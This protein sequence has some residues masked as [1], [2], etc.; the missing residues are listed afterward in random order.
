MGEGDEAMQTRGSLPIGRRGY[1]SLFGIG[2]MGM[3][4]SRAQA[5]EAK[6]RSP[7]TTSSDDEEI[8]RVRISNLILRER[9]ARDA[10]RWDE[11]RASYHPDST[12]DI[13]WFKGK[14]P[15]FVDATAELFTKRLRSFHQLEPPVV[16]INNDRALVDVGAAVHLPGFVGDVAV[17]VISHTRALYRVERSA[18]RWSISHLTSIYVRDSMHT[19]IPG[20]ALK[21]DVDKLMAFREPYRFLS[22]LL[23][24]S[25]YPPN[26]IL[27]GI[28]RQDLVDS[29]YD[30]NTR[31]LD[32]AARRESP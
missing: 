13:S 18:G 21:L 31:W 19:V 2:L 16:T 9:T 26:N 15:A 29:I 10:A 3:S 11:M 4:M 6:G 28:D 12:V 25:G 8:D 17:G 22:Y 14:G 30:Q 5:A 32:Q 1:L 7:A 27:P 20:A 23:A 24:Q